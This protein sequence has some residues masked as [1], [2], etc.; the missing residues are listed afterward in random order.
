MKSIP[1]SIVAKLSIMFSILGLLLVVLGI[2]I[3]TNVGIIVLMA[4]LIV[5]VGTIIFRILFY[6]CPHCEGFL[7]VPY[8]NHY[9]PHCGK[10]LS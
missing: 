6:R 7:N 2:C 1:L 5:L 4:G 3:G 9:C 10:Y 8:R